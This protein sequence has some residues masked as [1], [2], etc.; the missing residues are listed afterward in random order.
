[1]KNLSEMGVS[2]QMLKFTHNYLNER[3]IKVKRG[4]TIPRNH[5]TTAGV[6]QGGVLSATCFLLAIKPILDTLP[7]G[8]WGTLYAYDPVIYSTFKRLRTPARILQNF[9]RKLET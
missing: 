4:T 2:G 7:A 5:T 6:P 9:V 1:M 8:I 3:T